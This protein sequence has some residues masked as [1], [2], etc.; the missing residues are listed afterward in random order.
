LKA[1]FLL[2]RLQRACKE[3]VTRSETMQYQYIVQQSSQRRRAWRFVVSFLLLI[4][5]IVLTACQPIQPPAANTAAPTIPEVTIEVNDTEFIIPDNFPG[6]IVRVT[7]QNTGSKDLDVGI[8]RIREGTDV[9]ELKELGQNIP[10]NL[11]AILQQLGIMVSFNPVPAGGSEVAILDFRTGQF[12]ADASEH[13]EGEPPPGLL[14]YYGVFT[15]DEIVGTVEPQ[16]DV[17]V[18]M[19]DFAFIMP[20]EIRAGTQMWQYQNTGK[21]WHMQAL[22]KPNPDVT[23]EEIMAVM[24]SEGEPAGPPPFEFVSNVGLAPIGEGER[25]WLEFDLP[26]G[27]YLVFCPIPDVA[28]MMKGEPPMSHMAHGMHRLLTVK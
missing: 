20:D 24:M 10:D 2:Y 23:L 14:R 9:E 27:E 3:D 17:L 6:G 25:L 19:N 15:A 4:G 16:T 5:V 1:F 13:V 21:Q 12:I 18:E 7:I 26:A 8:S 22:I 28:A 11:F